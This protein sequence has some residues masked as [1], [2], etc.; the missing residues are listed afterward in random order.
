MLTRKRVL[1][2]RPSPF[3]IADL[4]RLIVVS[5]FARCFILGSLGMLSYSRPLG[6]PIRI[7]KGPTLLPPLKIAMLT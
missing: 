3:D 4:K 5:G 6:N 1:R 7:S 2:A